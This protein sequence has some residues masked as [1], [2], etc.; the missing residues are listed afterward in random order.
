MRDPSY[1]GLLPYDNSIIAQ[2]LDVIDLVLIEKTSNLPVE[3]KKPKT[4]KEKTKINRK[5]RVEII[6]D[7]DKTKTQLSIPDNI[8]FDTAFLDYLW[9]KVIQLFA[10]EK[11]EEDADGLIENLDDFEEFSDEPDY[12]VAY[13]SDPWLKAESEGTE[14]E[15]DEPEENTWTSF[16]VSISIVS[17]SGS[18]FISSYFQLGEKNLDLAKLVVDGSAGKLNNHAFNR[19]NSPSLLRI[20]I[21]SLDE[22][23]PTKRF[24]A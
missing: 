19:K 3:E 23:V 21:T 22:P 16:N 5:L 20:S 9:L 7:I 2:I 14:P 10:G 12:D 15:D 17:D 18:Y 1:D 24:D 6:T 11:D 8:I 13:D 4:T